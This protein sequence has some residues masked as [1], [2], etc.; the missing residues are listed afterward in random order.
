MIEFKLSELSSECGGTL[1][2]SDLEVK[3]VSTDSRSCSGALF[4][5]LTGERFDGHD[6]IKKAVENGAVAVVVS[7]DIPKCGV[8][9]VKCAD[10]VRALGTCGRLVRMRSKAKVASLT[11]SCGKTTVKELTAGILSKSGP[12]IATSGNFNN[13]IGVPLTLLRLERD[14]RFAVIEQGASH[15]HDIERT[16]EFVKAD[17]AL[18]NNAGAAHIEGFGS[19]RGVYEGKSEILQDVLGRGGIG[20]VPS[21]SNW[22]ESWKSDFASAFNDGRLVTFGTH[23]TD[24]VRVSSIETSQTGISFHI[25]VPSQNKGFD[26]ALPL[27]GA[28]NAMNAAAACALALI[29]GAPYENL[30]PG[31]LQGAPMRG[32]LFMQTHGDLSLIDDAYNA[33]FNA[34]IAALDVLSNAQGQRI[35][36][37]GDMGELGSEAL[38]LHRQVG[39]H[40]RGRCDLFLCAGPLAKATADAYGDGAEHFGSVDELIL[41]V[42]KLVSSGGKKC[43]LVKGSH[44]MGMD[45]VNDAVR[46]AGGF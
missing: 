30:K 19:L 43:F 16:C 44:A 29:T 6:F 12:T 35:M 11:G 26:A 33:S 15:P 36:V 2:G 14:T 9:V 7:K 27:L 17:T 45:R 22:T 42:E 40:A 21:D 39:E 28:H 4:V 25:D 24:L 13:D 1:G 41:R 38:N 23:E 10:T 31:L 5:A 34:V 32:R 8:S 46:R 20:A 18:I 3:A 37:F